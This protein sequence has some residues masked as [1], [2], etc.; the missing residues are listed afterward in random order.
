[1]SGVI[2]CLASMTIEELHDKLQWLEYKCGLN[3]VDGLDGYTSEDIQRSRNLLPEVIAE[4]NRR[5]K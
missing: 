5:T 2:N 1:M 3:A 4:I